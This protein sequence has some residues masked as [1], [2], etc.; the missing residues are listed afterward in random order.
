MSKQKIEDLS[1][2]IDGEYANDPDALISDICKDEQLRQSWARY[3]LISDCLKGHLPEQFSMSAGNDVR[4]LL[5]TEPTVLAPKH[6]VYHYLKP[7]VGFAIAA[8]VAVVAILAI[9]HNNSPL[10]GSENETLAANH[11]QS[12]QGNTEQYTFAASG[13]TQPVSTGYENANSRM[14]SYLVN[15]NEQRANAGM[16]GIFPYVRI[17]AHEKQE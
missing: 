17:V 15:Y 7:A 5:E 6:R 14:N 16:Q 10:T 8:S 12:V 4:R 13:T 11:K 2:L 1:A 9:Q 3:H